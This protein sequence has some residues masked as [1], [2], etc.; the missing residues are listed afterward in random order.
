[1][2]FS[3]LDE[4]GRARMVDISAKKI[5]RRRAWASGD[6]TLQRETL[7]LIK[8]RKMPKG[9]VLT[10][11]KIAAISAAKKTSGL[12]PLC[13][14]VPVTG[15]EM[16]FALKKDRIEVRSEISGEARTGFEM[17]ALTAVAVACLT[18]YDMCKAVDKKMTLGSIKLV[19]K[20]K[21][22]R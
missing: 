13:H 8:D 20:W 11:A 12:I 14:P 5:I 10:V 21:E 9:E 1:M 19:K 18:I 17:E 22:E 3:H 16:S 4:K 2:K 7:R 6:I 15:I